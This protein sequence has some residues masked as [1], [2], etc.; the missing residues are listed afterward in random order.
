[1]GLSDCPLSGDL[2]V[3]LLGRRLGCEELNG[4]ASVLYTVD[5]YR[6]VSKH[7]ILATRSLISPS[8]RE[9]VTCVDGSTSQHLLCKYTKLHRQTHMAF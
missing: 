5:G 6:G 2:G 3:S 1:M 4:E 9:F 7:P 8:V